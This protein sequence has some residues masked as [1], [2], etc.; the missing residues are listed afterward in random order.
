MTGADCTDCGEPTTAED[1][2]V[3]VGCNEV[4]HVEC[5]TACAACNHLHCNECIDYIHPPDDEPAGDYWCKDCQG[6][7]DALEKIR[8]G[9]AP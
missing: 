8:T 2:R 4:F 1:A 7:V 3:C 5:L 6:A 9:G